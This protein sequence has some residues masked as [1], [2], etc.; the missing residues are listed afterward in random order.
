MIKIPLYEVLI[1]VIPKEQFLDTR[2][3]NLETPKEQL[4]ELQWK[5]YNV[6]LQGQMLMIKD[7]IFKAYQ[8]GELVWLD[9]RNLKA[10]HPTH[11]L[12]AKQYGPFKFSEIISHIAYQLQLPPTW[13]IHNVFYA[14][15]LLPYKETQKYGIN[16]PKPPPE[17]I[18]G[19]PEWEV[20]AIVRKRQFGRNK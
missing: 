19:H 1:G 17:I 2:G 18:K 8:K 15:Y 16:F 10:T 3:G 9:A 12:R 7:T 13:K 14:S 6:I 20:E 4:R 5:A 11:K